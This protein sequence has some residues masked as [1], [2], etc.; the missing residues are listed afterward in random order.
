M[1]IEVPIAAVAMGAE[2]IEKH[3]TLDRKM[4]GPDHAASLNPA[5]LKEMVKGIRNIEKA[6]GNGEKIPS[7]SEKGN[8]IAAR[9]SIFARCDI[10]KGQ[11]FTEDN[12]IAKRP[13]G[14]INPMRWEEVIGTR[15]LRDFKRDEM[16]EL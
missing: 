14:G 6:I 3:F 5:E 2:I 11:P 8:R 7:N 15:A 10:K 4:E 1:G 13:G 9:K 16:I 12:I